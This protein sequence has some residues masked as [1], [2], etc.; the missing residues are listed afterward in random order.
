MS[1]RNPESE[2]LAWRDGE[3]KR[4]REENLRLRRLLAAHGI[5]V[6]PSASE[7][8]HLTQLQ[9][10]AATETKEERA[11]KRIVPSRR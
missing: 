3:N 2:L 6:P 11:R 5:A 10:P 7:D 9:E 1:S 4:L 8:D